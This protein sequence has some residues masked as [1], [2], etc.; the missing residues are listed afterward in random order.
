MATKLQR[1]GLLQTKRRYRGDFDIEG[2]L[3][4]LIEVDMF[5][6]YAKLLEDRKVKFVEYRLNGRASVWWDRL[7]EMRMREGR[8]LVQ[9]WRRMKQLL[10]GRF[11][12]PDYEQYIYFA[13][14]PLGRVDNV[15]ELAAE[16]GC[17]VGPLPSMYLGLPLGA[18][19]RA[20]GVWDSIEDR[21]RRRLAT[22]KRQYISKGG[23]ITLIRST[24]SSLPIYFLSLFRM[25]KSVCSRLEKIQRDFLWG[26]GNLERKPHLVNWKTVCLQKSHGG[27]GVR[28]L[29]KMNIAL[30]CK[31]CWRFANERDSLWRLVIST[32]FGEGDGGWNTNDMREG[33]GTGL[34]K[35]ISKEW[36]TFYQNS[37]SC[38][39][40][41]RRLRF[42]KDPWCGGTALCNAFP[43]LFNLAALKDASVAEVWDSTRGDGGWS[44][45]FQRPFNDWEMEE[46]ERFLLVLQNKKIK[47]FQEDCLTLKET[48]PDGF[49]VSLMYQIL[50]QSLPSDFPWQSI[51]NPIVPPKMG[52]LR[53]KRPGARCL[54]LIN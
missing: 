21:F 32:K 38:L 24:L 45:V 2:F 41:G 37:N 8:G 51:W 50:M 11:L 14:I 12:P 27:L 44:P 9:T 43:T 4:W 13:I 35:D 52:S 17:G 49:A 15:E 6:E 3:D 47:P 20:L 28:S 1:R 33:Y 53:G 16:L 54:R 18:P 40:N 23:R 10:R 7:R 31:W 30:F 36:I 22:W 46:V 19:H 29:S 5:F 26:G 25:P 42:W 48:R 34:W 39:G